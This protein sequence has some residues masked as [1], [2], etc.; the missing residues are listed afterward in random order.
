MGFV[1]YSAHLSNVDFD[2]CIN[3][4]LKDSFGNILVRI[5]ILSCFFFGGKN[6]TIPM[7]CKQYR[8]NREACHYSFEE[9]MPFNS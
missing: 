3:P 2:N 6:F 5:K 4:Y 7:K 1:V 9:F 8:A